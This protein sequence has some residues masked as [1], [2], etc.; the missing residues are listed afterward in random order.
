MPVHTASIA[1]MLIGLS[2]GNGGVLASWAFAAAAPSTA[3]AT[4]HIARFISE[5]SFTSRSE[6]S[7]SAGCRKQEHARVITTRARLAQSPALQF[8]LAFWNATRWA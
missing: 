3:I 4:A 1:R 8:L 7:R 5:R 2:T 6:L